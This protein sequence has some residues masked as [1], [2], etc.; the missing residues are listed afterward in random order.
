M[1]DAMLNRLPRTPLALSP[2]DHRIVV[3][4]WPMPAQTGSP[5]SMFVDCIARRPSATFI[6][7]NLLT[8]PDGPDWRTLDGDRLLAQS[9]TVAV[10]T[11]EA[12]AAACC[13]HAWPLTHFVVEE[14][15]YGV[16]RRARAVDAKGTPA[17]SVQNPN[18]YLFPIVY[19]IHSSRIQKYTRRMYDGLWCSY[20]SAT[21]PAL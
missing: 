13:C 12:A 2:F 17:F 10:G 9:L 16:L 21:M 14:E 15:D 4:A 19:M 1:L 5:Q 3:R 8:A 18:I 20:V 7:D 6:N 11:C